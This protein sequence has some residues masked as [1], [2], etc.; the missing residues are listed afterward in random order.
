MVEKMIGLGST[1]LHFLVCEVGV[2]V[3]ILGCW[4]KEMKV[5]FM[6]KR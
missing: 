4:L 6:L 1:M 3:I 5:F 2:P